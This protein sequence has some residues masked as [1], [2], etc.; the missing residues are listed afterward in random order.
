MSDPVRDTRPIAELRRQAVS[1][2]RIRLLSW[3]SPDALMV[4]RDH[5]AADIVG[6]EAAVEAWVLARERRK[7]LARGGDATEARP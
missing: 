5:L 7:T 6:F 3:V 4:V 1:D 2:W